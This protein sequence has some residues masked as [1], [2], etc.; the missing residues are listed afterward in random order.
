MLAQYEQA[1]ED[2]TQAA[3]R[4][5]AQRSEA[6]AQKA[7]ENLVQLRQLLASRSVMPKVVERNG[8]RATGLS[9]VV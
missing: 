1:M 8:V 5:A 3:E 9:G 6:K 2:L 7:R 4:F